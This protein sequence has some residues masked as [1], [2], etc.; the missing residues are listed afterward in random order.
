VFDRC[1]ALGDGYMDTF[2]GINLYLMQGVPASK[3]VMGV[4]WRGQVWR[5]DNYDPASE[6]VDLDLCSAPLVGGDGFLGVNCSDLNAGVKSY[7]DALDL[8]ASDKPISSLM[9][10]N[11][12][13]S[14]YFN[15]LEDGN[16][17]Q[18]WHQDT[19]TLS[20]KYSLARELE[21]RGVG[22]W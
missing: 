11:Y 3:L 5:C 7:R 20:M 19:K 6:S 16:L 12:V 22:P 10:D 9:W 2:H 15:Y 18:V 1:T 17:F 21:L 13:K 14:T 4:P 8:L